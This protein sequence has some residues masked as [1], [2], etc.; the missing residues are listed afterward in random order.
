MQFHF[1]PVDHNNQS[2]HRLKYA[3]EN[4]PLVHE[5]STN[6]CMCLHIICIEGIMCYVQTFPLMHFTSTCIN[7]GKCVFK[8]AKWGMMLSLF[9]LKYPYAVFLIYTDWTQI[10]T[11]SHLHTSFKMVDNSCCPNAKNPCMHINTQYRKHFGKP[12]LCRHC[13]DHHAEQVV[14]IHFFTQLHIAMSIS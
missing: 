5:L 10:C 9:I 12:C 2:L 14:Y 1:A 6:T 3:E 8:Q 13:K 4:F 7:G 11:S